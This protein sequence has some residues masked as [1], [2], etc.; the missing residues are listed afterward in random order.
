LCLEKH[1]LFLLLR[2]SVNKCR[3]EEFLAML[4][5]AYYGRNGVARKNRATPKFSQF[6]RNSTENEVSCALCMCGS[7]D[8]QPA[9]IAKRLKPAGNIGSLI[10]NHGR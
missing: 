5:G 1:F 3:I 6:N 10:A 2:R 9:I 8:H 7:M 4:G